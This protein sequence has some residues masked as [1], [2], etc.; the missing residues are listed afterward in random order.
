MASKSRKYCAKYPCNQ[1]AVNGAYCNEHTPAPA[2]KETDPFYLSVQWR[3]FREWYLGKHP[4]CEKCKAEGRGD[5]VAEMVDH[6]IE[7]K[8]GGELTT[9]DNA[10]AMCWKCHAIK[11]AKAV[12][13]R[14]RYGYNRT[15]PQTRT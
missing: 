14:K 4:L 1:L 8:D 6:I 12:N 2:P 5:I 3:R 7:I 9:E 13:H 15:A 11:T 10:M